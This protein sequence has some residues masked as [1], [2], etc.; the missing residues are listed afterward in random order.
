ME[1]KARD[2]RYYYGIELDEQMVCK[3]IYWAN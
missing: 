3:S 1:T 2:H